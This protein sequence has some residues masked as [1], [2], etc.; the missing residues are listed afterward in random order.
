MA[1]IDP[2]AEVV[3]AVEELSE[4]DLQ[5]VAELFGGL[6]EDSQNSILEALNGLDDAQI[7]VQDDGG[8]TAVGT[9][10]NGEKVTTAIGEGSFSAGE[11]GGTILGTEGSQ[12]IVGGE[13]ADTMLGG[14]GNDTI[15]AGE[16]D[17]IGVDGGGD[18]TFGGLADGATLDFSYLNIDGGIDA[19]ASAITNISYEDVDNDGTDDLVVE[20]SEGSSITLLGVGNVEDIIDQI[21]V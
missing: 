20:F 15:L 6:S 13:G 18:K 16:G 8:V 10:D 1:S 9:D 3:T 4:Q 12:L 14:I 19:L 2:N 17:T 7:T 5:V 11:E 21:I